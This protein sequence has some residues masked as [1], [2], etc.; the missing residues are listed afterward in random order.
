MT[1]TMNWIAER[2]GDDP[3][4]AMER[5]FS[6]MAVEDL[7]DAKAEAERAGARELQAEQ[8]AFAY[9]Q[10]NVRPGEITERAMAIGDLQAERADLLARAA[11]LE[12][13]ISGLVRV[14]RDDEKRV[15]LA[16]EMVS[17]SAPIPGLGDLPRR[18][19]DVDHEVLIAARARSGI[20]KIDALRRRGE[21]AA[22]VSRSA[23]GRP[24]EFYPSRPREVTRDT[25]Q[26]EGW[27]SQGLIVRST[28]QYGR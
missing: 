8:R 1:D 14:Q 4:S 5:A 22:E 2:V 23:S 7:A 19:R 18:V 9:R 21:A 13:R 17:R 26:Y 27:A 3:R 6:S 25:S 12:E 24:H 20:A 16:A 15:E 11:V 10:A 28:D